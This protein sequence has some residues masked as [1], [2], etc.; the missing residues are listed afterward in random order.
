LVQIEDLASTGSGERKEEETVRELAC[1]VSLRCLEEVEEE[2]DGAERSV[3]VQE[4]DA[5]RS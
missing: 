2:I 3:Q 5:Q 1:E 4:E